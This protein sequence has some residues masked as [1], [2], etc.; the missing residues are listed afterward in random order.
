M[1]PKKGSQADRNAKKK[2]A[3]EAEKQDDSPQATMG[4]DSSFKE[5]FTMLFLGS[6]IMTVAPKLE[7][8]MKDDSKA[9]APVKKA[10]ED[11]K[12]EG[13]DEK[14][15][16][17]EVSNGVN[18]SLEYADSVFAFL[19]KRIGLASWHNC[20]GLA[21][22]ASAEESLEAWMRFK[23]RDFD[24]GPKAKKNKSP[25]LDRM[26]LNLFTFMPQYLHILLVL[27]A[28]RTVL[29]G[30]FFACLPW[31][32]GWQILS[33]WIPLD[34]DIPKLP[35][36]KEHIE[37]CPVKFR[38]AA[39]VAIHALVWLFFVYEVLWGIGSFVWFLEK[40][41][42]FGAISY[43]AYAVKSESSS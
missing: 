14:A 41:M 17:G 33:L 25:G 24:G 42:V 8:I 28:L 2:A 36:L 3:K 13:E 27:M 10:E 30:S 39:S 9:K 38:V 23:N 29:F 12:A 5:L 26:K 22:P 31:L 40:G 35:Q 18:D 43:H 19:Q 16:E 11:E 34:G 6:A 1:A 32:L 37:K 7:A 15:D 20:L 21:L 4:T